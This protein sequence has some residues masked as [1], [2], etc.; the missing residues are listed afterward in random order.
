MSATVI[1]TGPTWTARVCPASTADSAAVSSKSSPTRQ[2]A[3]LR[4]TPHLRR[5]AHDHGAHPFKNVVTHP[6]RVRHDREC[7]V[8]RRTRREEAAIDH[9]KVVEVVC[10]A[11]DVKR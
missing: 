11:V 2:I 5:I 3:R 10:L 6:Q 4:N 1:T 7:R 9:V 8:H